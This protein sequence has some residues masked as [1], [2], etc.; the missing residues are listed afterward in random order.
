MTPMMLISMRKAAALAFA[1]PGMEVDIANGNELIA[2]VE[3]RFEGADV[4]LGTTLLSPC[5][6]RAAVGRA[7]AHM[8]SGGRALFFGLA[9][10]ADLRLHHFMPFTGAA[11]PLGMIVSRVG[12][13][14]VHVFAADLEPAQALAI[15]SS[16]GISSKGIPSACSADGEL[17]VEGVHVSWDP[18]AQVSLVHCETR[19]STLGAMRARVECSMGELMVQMGVAEILASVGASTARSSG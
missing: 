1:V 9:P 4:P 14:I 19:V 8:G 18:V 5:A 12:E 16:T 3:R 10:D 6:F 17:G 15:I 2:R 7:A 13:A 11:T